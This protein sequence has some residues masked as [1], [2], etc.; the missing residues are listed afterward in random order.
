MHIRI[1]LK[2]SRTE[3]Q[4]IKMILLLTLILLAYREK[5]KSKRRHKLSPKQQ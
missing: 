1:S 4:Y 3:K 2:F 5:V